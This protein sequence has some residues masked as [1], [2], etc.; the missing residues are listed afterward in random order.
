MKKKVLIIGPFPEPTTGVSLAN[1]VVFEYLSKRGNYEVEYI[2]TSY[3]KFDEDLGSFSFSKIS[4]YLKINFQ[5][6]KVFKNDI[7]Y[8]TPGQTFFGV[9]KYAL[10]FILS[11]LL[12]KEIIVHVHGNHL[13]KEYD[14]LKGFKKQ[15]F[16]KLLQKTSKGI[17]LSES[18]KGNMS[19]FIKDENIHVVYNFVE[20]YLIVGE[21]DLKDKFNNTHL[22]ILFLSNL[23]EEKGILDLLEALL[24]LEKEGFKY[25][26]KIA[27]NIDER[28]KE[29]IETYFKQLNHTEYCGIVS[30]N[31][32]KSLLLWGDT[33]VLPTYYSME[34]QPISIL[35]A[36]VT[37]N[38]ILATRHAG[39][40]DIFVEEENG[41][42]VQKQDFKSILE[43]IKQAQTLN[44]KSNNIRMNNYK[45]AK[46][47]Y[48]VHSFINNIE[49]VFQA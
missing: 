31:A 10:F 6:Y 7:I 15:F 8:L 44:Q 26:A 25:E 30:G 18:L 2:N 5:L 49:M 17:V 43:K 16:S 47:N 42:Y 21:E 45:I 24:V 35:E 13:G 20:D 12:K 38:V 22:R 11:S 1:K 9:V 40:P 19:P 29:K 36:M 23:M 27:G 32:K 46:E 37:G 28:L 48:R 34:G 4:F 33:F 39:I 3:N 41:F 14:S